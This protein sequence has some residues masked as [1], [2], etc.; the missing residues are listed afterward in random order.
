M[1]II[2]GVNVFPSQIEHALIEIEGTDPN[3]VIVLDRGAKAL[4]EV[5]LQVEVK[6]ELFT[7]ET[8]SLESLK[9]KIESV[10]KS[11]LGIQLKVKLV[12]PKTIERS[13]GKAK[14]VIDRRTI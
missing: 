4:D 9:A 7:D 6:R 1:L 3:Y 8:K 2:R 12:E 11:K 14:R 13:V 10:M 5:E